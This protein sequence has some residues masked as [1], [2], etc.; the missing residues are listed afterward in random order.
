MVESRE[1]EGEPVRSFTGVSVETTDG[2]RWNGMMMEK[3]MA[4]MER[5]LGE[6]REK[7]KES[8]WV[9]SSGR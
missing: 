7:L 2:W 4:G 9:G 6:D 5:K 1:K 8:K 3:N